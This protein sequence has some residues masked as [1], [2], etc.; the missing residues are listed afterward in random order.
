MN[1]Y[2]NGGLATKF[3]IREALVMDLIGR[4]LFLQKKMGYPAINGNR[5]CRMSAGMLSAK[6][7]MLSRSSAQRILRR[8]VN[9]NVLKKAEY[10]RSRFDRTASY[11]FTGYRKTLMEEAY[12]GR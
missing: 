4:E 8:L 5:W 3:G 1:Y 7:P 9:R 6:L 11:A 10:N 2:F 12:A